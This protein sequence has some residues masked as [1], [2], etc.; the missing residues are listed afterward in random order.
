MPPV[1]Q[2]PPRDST[3]VESE[4]PSSGIRVGREMLPEVCKPAGG[5]ACGEFGPGWKRGTIPGCDLPDRPGASPT[6]TASL[7][8][9]RCRRWWGSSVIPTGG[10][11]GSSGA[12]KNGGWRL[13]AYAP[14]RLRSG[15][16]PG[17]R[18]PVRRDADLRG[19]RSASRGV[20]PLRHGETRTA[21]L[22]RRQPRYTKRFAFY[23]GGRC[24]SAPI[25]DIAEELHLEWHTVKELEMQYMREQ[26]R[27]AGTP[28]PEV[29]G[30]DEVSIRKRHTYRIVVSDL[31]RRRPI[32][33]G[34]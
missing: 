33:F 12:Q 17:S 7:A 14:R 10:S 19:D 29:I 8:S 21:G 23:V 30:I 5:A 24:R 3:G 22:P 4:R 20:P 34:G 6:R 11:S 25:Y 18:S 31:I 26:L 15:R 16:A 32:W 9:A 13:R 1:S 2:R 27:R 28:K